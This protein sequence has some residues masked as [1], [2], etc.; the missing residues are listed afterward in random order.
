MT[1][2]TPFVQSDFE[3]VQRLSKD[4][5]NS[6][7]ASKT[8]ALRKALDGFPEFSL[9]YFKHKITRRPRMKGRGGMVFGNARWE[10]N[11]W[12]F[13][14]VGGDQ[15]QVQLNI[16]MSP[17]HIRVGLGFMIGRQVVPKPPAFN[18][19]QTFL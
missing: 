13:Y 19:F 11:Y 18:V 14:N 6:Q 3:L 1:N 5:P 12:Y 9:D 16:G 2:F 7:L 4:E 17:S 8:E 10:N 15:D